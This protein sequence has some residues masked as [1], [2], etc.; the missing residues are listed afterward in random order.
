MMP[1]DQLSVLPPL[2]VLVLENAP[3]IRLISQGARSGMM[4][5]TAGA[6]VTGAAVALSEGLVV[7]AAVRRL[8]SSVWSSVSTFTA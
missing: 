4:G 8:I 1:L 6:A 3:P 2:Y 5:G 7:D